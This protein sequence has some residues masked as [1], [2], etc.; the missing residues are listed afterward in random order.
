MSIREY[1]ANDDNGVD[2]ADYPHYCQAKGSEPDG[3]CHAE[4]DYTCNACDL[5]ICRRC[6]RIAG[7]L[8]GNTMLLCPDCNSAQKE[9][10]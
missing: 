9:P 10:A 6:A 5:H 7:S 8:D 1:S 2:L 4:A 3:Q